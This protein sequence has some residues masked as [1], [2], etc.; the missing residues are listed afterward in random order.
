V[1][2]D[3]PF[4]V[5]AYRSSER[6]GEAWAE[7]PEDALRAGQQLFDDAVALL[8]VQG[9]RRAVTVTFLVHLDGEPEPKHVA[10]V[11]GRRP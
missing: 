6:V 8:D 9:A 3:A 10:T 5:V 1:T 11:E 4:E 2:S 7:T